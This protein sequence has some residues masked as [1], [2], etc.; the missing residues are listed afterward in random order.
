[1]QTTT[2]KLFRDDVGNLVLDPQASLQL[3]LEDFGTEA[4]AAK[5]PDLTEAIHISAETL[6]TF[7]ERAEVKAT[8]V[9]QGE[10]LTRSTKPWVRK[11]R[12]DST[13]PE[14]LMSDREGRFAEEEQRAAKKAMTDDVSY[15][16]SSSDADVE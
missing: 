13:P 15:K 9:K 1:V 2:D 16:A 7:L 3:R 11:R 14:Q 5:F 4:F 12:R 8:R 10:G 6:F